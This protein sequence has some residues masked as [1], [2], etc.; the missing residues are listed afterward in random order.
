MGPG[1]DV[2]VLRPNGAQRFFDESLGKHTSSFLF[3]E[4]FSESENLPGLFVSI[5]PGGEG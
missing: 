5:E 1:T 2:L 4:L 3:I